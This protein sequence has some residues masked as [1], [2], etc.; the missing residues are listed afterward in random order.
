MG[1][2]RRWRTLAIGLG[3]AALVLAAANAGLIFWVHVRGDERPEVPPPEVQSPQVA[4][5][6]A[7]A[8]RYRWLDRDA[9]IAEIPVERALEL[10]ATDGS[11]PP[12]AAPQPADA[13][14]G[15]AR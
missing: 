4:A 13:A 3:A 15:G 14:A 5:S 10:L 8:P 12:G 7:E 2:A 11:S 6:R 1:P 9:G